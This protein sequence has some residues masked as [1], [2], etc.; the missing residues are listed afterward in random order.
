[1]FFGIVPDYGPVGGIDPNVALLWVMIWT[2]VL[3]GVLYG[4]LFFKSWPTEETPSE[5]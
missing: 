3:G 1:M 5:E 4:S 2:F